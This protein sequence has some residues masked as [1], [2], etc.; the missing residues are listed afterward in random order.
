MGQVP[1]SIHSAP[2]L[3]IG[4]GRC[5]RHLHHYFDLL[6]I[7]HVCW[8]RKE[9]QPLE[10]KLPQVDKVMVCISDAAIQPLIQR[11]QADYPNLLWIHFSGA[12]SIPEA[13]SAHP[14]MTFADRLYPPETY[15]S[16]WFVTEQGRLAF[17]DLFPE[18]PNPNIA[19]P[20]AQ[21]PYYHAWTSLAGN[22]TTL[23]W[24]AYSE[25]M[26]NQFSI[27]DQ[28]LS[29]YLRAITENIIQSDHPMTGPVVR[30][31]W[32]TITMHQK[33]LDQDEFKPV[34]EA[35]VSLSKT[36]RESTDA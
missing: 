5:A 29:L 12:L 17:H 26:E 1:K 32:E 19:I 7:P 13:E 18:L 9:N 22:F 14:L 3:L 6:S 10:A 4:G 23:L 27:P 15:P 33:S 28:A 8:S 11:Y 31:D 36:R 16:I 34:Y 20:P 35:L 30:G 25:R 2:Y 24:Q 21:K